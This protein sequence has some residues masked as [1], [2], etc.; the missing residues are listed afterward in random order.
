M[1]DA[2]T[3][4]PKFNF[5][6]KKCIKEEHKWIWEKDLNN[7]LVGVCEYCNQV[8]DDYRTSEGQI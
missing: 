3:Y 4:S 6:K 1:Q 5:K 8:N 2:P 7:E